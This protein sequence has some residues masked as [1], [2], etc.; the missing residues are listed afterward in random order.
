M[1]VFT[2]LAEN[3]GDIIQAV[4]G[5]VTIASIIAAII[6][7]P[8]KKG[9]LSKILKLISVLALNIGKAKRKE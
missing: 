3:S 1:D 9:K 2:S 8:S 5:V 7:T 4:T 6:K